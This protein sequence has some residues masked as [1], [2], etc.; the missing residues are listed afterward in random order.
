ML[1]PNHPPDD[2]PVFETLG[3]RLAFVYHSEGAKGLRE[4]LFGLV[5]S[6]KAPRE[7]L[8]EAADELTALGITRVARLVA[9]AAVQ[10]PSLTDMRFCPYLQ[11]PYTDDPTA[12]GANIRSWLFRR[13]RLS[14]RIRKRRQA[15]LR[16]A[17]IDPESVD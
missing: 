7:V 16:R 17:G 2:E 5:E 1:A 14:E 8:G 13:K 9:E 6:G 12:N 15:L 3:A 10:C 4:L 11:P